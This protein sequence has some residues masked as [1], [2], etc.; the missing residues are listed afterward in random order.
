MMFKN[1]LRN[2]DNNGF[3]PEG[4]FVEIFYLSTYFPNIGQ[5]AGPFDSLLPFA[6]LGFL[7]VSCY[8]TGVGILVLGAMFEGISSG[9]ALIAFAA[10]AW[11]VLAVVVIA[12]VFLI[13]YGILKLV[14]FFKR[15]NPSTIGDP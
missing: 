7:A 2:Y 11:C 12:T 13:A 6:T 4:A 10:G 5:W 14:Q 3:Q 9:T 8:L 1:S 15:R